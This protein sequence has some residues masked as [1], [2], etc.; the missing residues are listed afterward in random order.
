[1]ETTGAVFEP[2]FFSHVQTLQDLGISK[3]QPLS[4]HPKVIMPVVPKHLERAWKN[5]NTPAEWENAIGPDDNP[6]V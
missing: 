3:L 2:M 1:V 6:R 5:V 4:G